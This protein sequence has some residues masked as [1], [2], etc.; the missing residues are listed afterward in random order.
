MNQFQPYMTEKFQRL[1][2]AKNL[3]ITLRSGE[4]SVSAVTEDHLF[5]DENGAPEAAISTISYLRTDDGNLQRPVMFI[6]NGGPG[7]ATSMLQ[8]ECFGPYCMAEDEKEKPLYAL[9]VEENTILDICDLV[10]M[11]PIGVGYSR[12]LREDAG[13]KYF[14]VDGDARS[15]AFAIVNWLKRHQRWNSPVYL[16]GESYGTIR[17][18][19][20]L[21]ELDRDPIHG[22]RMMLGLPVAGVV[23][24][25]SALSIGKEGNIIEPSLDLVTAALPSMAAINWYHNHQIEYCCEDFVEEAWTFARTKL[26]PAL[27][28]GDACGR[29][30]V[31]AIAKELEKYTGM[32]AAYFENSRLQLRS[33][34]DFMT[35]VVCHKNL[36]VDLYDGRITSPLAGAYN[37][38]G[39]GNM[40]I[41]VM[42]G[43]L[44]QTL[45][46]A[47]KRMYY[48]GNLNMNLCW[49]YAVENGKSHMECLRAAAERMPQMKI[50]VASGLYDLCT[51]AGNTRYQ[52]AHSGIAAGRVLSRE[53]AGGHGVYSSKE[54]KAAFLQ[55]VREFIEE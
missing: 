15:M 18:C 9:N 8:L 38:V 50:L 1:D 14:S 21:D 13:E 4:I 40:P 32:D 46:T 16:C 22:N 12:L 53:Y 24:I 33:I 47:Q 31:K 30:E 55:D 41:M 34:S 27:F 7:S 20:V 49:N 37:A 42:N 29:Q 28:E 44:S 5:Y 25:G 26:L 54:A 19:R 51:L 2:A 23:L 35:Q 10:Y 17:A 3:E 52:F 36:R 48:T 6:W 39:N 45:G 11:D 43:I